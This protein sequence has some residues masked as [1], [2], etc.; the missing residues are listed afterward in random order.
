MDENKQKIC[1]LLAEALRATRDHS[2]LTG[3]RYERLGESTERHHTAPAKAASGSSKEERVNIEKTVQELLLKILEN[4]SEAHA[5]PAKVA[6]APEVAKILLE[7]V[8]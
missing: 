1:D 3:I 8:M 7:Y 4:V 2:D 6:I 5:D